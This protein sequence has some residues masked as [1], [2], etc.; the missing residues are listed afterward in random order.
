MLRS[1]QPIAVDKRLLESMR[2]A[3]IKFKVNARV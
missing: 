2:E 3:G 1:R